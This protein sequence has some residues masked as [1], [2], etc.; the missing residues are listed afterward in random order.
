M[1]EN[2]L[3]ASSRAYIVI[4]DHILDGTHAPG[5]M[6][7]EA[8]LA[9]SMGLSRTPV[10]AALA[11]LQDEGWIV[12]Y[13][14]RGAVVQGLSERAVA[15]LGDA[16]LA[17]ESSSVARAPEALR[18]RLADRME[19]SL[20]DQRAAF[21]DG[22]VREFIELTL[23][24]HRGFVEAGGNGVLLELY[25]RLADRQRF[26]LFQA[27]DRLLRR[28]EEIISEHEAL[29]A[30]LRSGDGE[31]F[32]AALRDHIAETGVRPLSSFGFDDATTFH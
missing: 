19:S 15:E 4:R 11:R 28:C 13:P 30:L 29:T 17:L 14:K 32:T 27:G 3:S 9:S 2:D 18:C 5:E 25:D 6:L 10:R 26:V 1:T 8:S 12:I 23:R 24:F 21:A 7:G 22:D 16:R 31:G 20:A